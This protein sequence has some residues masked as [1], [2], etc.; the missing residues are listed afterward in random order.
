MWHFGWFSLINWYHFA[1]IPIKPYFHNFART[2]SNESSVEKE[3]L[4]VWTLKKHVLSYNGEMPFK[5]EE[6]VPGFSQNSTLKIHLQSHTWDK[7]IFV[8]SAKRV[9]FSPCK[10]EKAYINLYWREGPCICEKCGVYYSKSIKVIQNNSFCFDDC[11]RLFNLFRFLV[12][13]HF[14][15]NDFLGGKGFLLPNRVHVLSL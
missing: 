12:D 5:Y 3:L 10:I 14:F 6:C 7:P 9:F 11:F 4:W 15:P 2:Y 1:T 13:C 8:S